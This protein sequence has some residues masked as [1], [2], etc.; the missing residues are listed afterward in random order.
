MNKSIESLL[1]QLRIDLSNP[2]PGR[3]AQYRMAPS[4]RANDDLYYDTPRPDARRGGVL[5]LL[6]PQENRLY[7][8]LILRPTYEGVH[9]GQIGLPGG[10][11]EMNDSDL[12]ATALREAHEEIG[13]LVESVTLLGQ[14][15]PLYVFAS[16]YLVQPTVGWTP[17]R[18]QFNLD[19]HE[20]EMLLEVSLLD[21]LDPN[22][23][24]RETWELRG[25]M[26]QVPFFCIQ[27]QKIWG[28]TAMILSELLALPALDHLPER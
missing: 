12:T 9:S 6:Y 3:T 28:A 14:L 15:S 19:P 20:V 5:I 11:Y 27:A 18:P 10:G 24:Q 23:Y 7:I 22:H 8:P 26:V 16:N 17:Q 4:P 13:V 2:L 1:S 25:R 21:L